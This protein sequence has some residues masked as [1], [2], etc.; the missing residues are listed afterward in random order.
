MCD[1]LVRKG[2]VHRRHDRGDR[3]QI[4][5]A[6]A[7]PGRQLVDSVTDRRRKA[8]ADLLRSVPS[9]E[10]AALIHSLQ[11]LAQAAGEVPEQSWSTGWDL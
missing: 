8:I 7:A 6:L 1:R 3:R 9:K 11:S 4:R 10:Q 2:L 5:V